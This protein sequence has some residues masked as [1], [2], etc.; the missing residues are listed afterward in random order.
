MRA[1]VTD[2]YGAEMAVAPTV[3]FADGSTEVEYSWAR[4][5]T[6][7]RGRG[8][9]AVARIVQGWAEDPEDVYR[10]ET[11]GPPADPL[12]LPVVASYE[13]LADTL[14]HVMPAHLER[15]EG[16]EV[17]HGLTIEE[18]GGS[19]EVSTD[20]WYVDPRTVYVVASNQEVFPDHTFVDGGSFEASWA[21]GVLRVTGTRSGLGSLR[22]SARTPDYRSAS[23]SRPVVVDYC[24]EPDRT[25]LNPATP[26]P[27]I[28]Y[29]RAPASATFRI[30]LRFKGEWSECARRV[31]GYAAGF[32]EAALAPN[33]QPPFVIEVG[34]GDCRGGVGVRVGV[35][36]GR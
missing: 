7:S 22:V 25:R 34:Y 11:G 30:E 8:G 33:D 5:Y 2:Q 15:R 28:K 18:V 35:G 14:V 36:P 21:D 24:P 1:S 3:A 12:F 31:V 17:P 4:F 20:D 23:L 26:R 29:D 10:I 19:L 6:N 9:E 13:G 27:A 16:S 32:F